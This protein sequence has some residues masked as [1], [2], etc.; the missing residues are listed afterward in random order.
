MKKIKISSLWCGWISTSLIVN[1]IKD[2]TK[3]E[4]ELVHP[5]DSDI[6]FF[7][8]YD[9]LSI[10]R[11]FLKLARENFT[12]IDKL[13]PNID[14]YLLKRKIKP[15]RVFLSYENT[16]FPD[17]DYDF[18]IT[19]LSNISDDRHLRLPIWKEMIDW[20]HLGITRNTNNFIKRFDNFFNIN[21]LMKEQGSDF[22]KKKKKYLYFLKPYERAKKKYDKFFF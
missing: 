13:F 20:S 21:E 19:S 16:N 14:F 6:L 11:R 22:L 5:S 1:L 9:L 15:I 7:G 17:F 12:T 8:P 18:G 2:I 4:I 10:K 3:R